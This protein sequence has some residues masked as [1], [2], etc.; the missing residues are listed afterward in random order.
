MSHPYQLTKRDWRQIIML[1]LVGF[2]SLYGMAANTTT[3][4][5]PSPPVSAPDASPFDHCLRGE[6]D[7]ASAQ[8]GMTSFYGETRCSS[9]HV[10][11]L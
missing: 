10:A 1:L 8:R 6:T 2:G 9:C 5:P 7:T 11:T 3:A 4:K